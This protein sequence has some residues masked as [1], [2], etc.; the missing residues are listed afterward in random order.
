MAAAVGKV[1]AAIF[2]HL[3]KNEISFILCRFVF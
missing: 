1:V 3:F 2:W